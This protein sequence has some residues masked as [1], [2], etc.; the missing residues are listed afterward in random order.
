MILLG[1]AS[2]GG[3]EILGRRAFGRLGMHLANPFRRAIYIRGM[4]MTDGLKIII[5]GIPYAVFVR[6]KYPR[7]K[8][9]NGGPLSQFGLET[10]SR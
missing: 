2:L 1:I 5:L 6:K 10:P 8:G 9:K 7:I 3:E 4:I